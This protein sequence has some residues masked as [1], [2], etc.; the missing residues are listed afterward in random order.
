MCGIAGIAGN[1]T[2]SQL[3]ALAEAMAH[4]GPDGEGIFIDPGAGIGLA[5]RRLA[6]IDPTSA[7]SQPM[8]SCDGRYQVV[9]NGEIYNFHE[10]AAELRQVDQALKGDRLWML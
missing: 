10:V 4:R 2:R 1:V 5:H 6:I 9:F 8:E 3:Q 7:A